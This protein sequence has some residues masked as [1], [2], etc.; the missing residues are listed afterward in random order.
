VNNASEDTATNGDDRVLI[1]RRVVTEALSAVEALPERI[2]AHERET[3]RIVERA[4][5]TL[6]EM[7]MDTVNAII[8]GIPAAITRHAPDTDPRVVKAICASVAQHAAAR[9]Q[10]LAAAKALLNQSEGDI[11]PENPC[12]T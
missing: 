6:N 5:R 8:E 7:T 10:T 2:Q 9:V 3:M 11:P 12:S 4:F 1:A